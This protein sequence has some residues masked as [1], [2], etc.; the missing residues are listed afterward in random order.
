MTYLKCLM[1]VSNISFSEY[2]LH[3]LS[4]SSVCIQRKSTL[5][6]AKIC[7]RNEKNLVNVAAATVSMAAELIFLKYI[8]LCS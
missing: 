6:S 8:L 7:S 2:I 3:C 5:E 4:Y 1:M